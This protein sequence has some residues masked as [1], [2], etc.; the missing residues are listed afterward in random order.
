[1]VFRNSRSNIVLSAVAP[2][3]DEQKIM[4]HAALLP[5]IGIADVGDS[6]SNSIFII[7]VSS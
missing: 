1:M 7:M 6:I 3:R 2:E 4:T 5:P